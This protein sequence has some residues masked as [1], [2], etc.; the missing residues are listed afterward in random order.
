LAAVVGA[1]S[2][3]GSLLVA[4]VPVPKV[5]YR[6]VAA[7]RSHRPNVAAPLAQRWAHGVQLGA[8]NALTDLGEQVAAA[9][10]F[11]EDTPVTPEIRALL[12]GVDAGLR[13]GLGKAATLAAHG[14]LA[15]ADDIASV[16]AKALAAVKQTRA[17]IAWFAHTAI[18]AG[19]QAVAEET[20][21]QLCWV[22]ERDA[23]L[24]CLALSG[25]VVDP[26]EEFPASAT[27]GTHQMP[28]FPIHE[29]AP[30]LGPP[31]HPNCR[32]GLRLVRPDDRA[33]RDLPAALKR[34]AERSVAR[35][36]SNHASNRERLTAAD[37][38]LKRTTSRLPKTVR[39]RAK[40]DMARGQFS[41]RHNRNLPVL[42]P[43]Q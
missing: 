2:I 12:R 17:Q 3:A 40:K 24:V 20:G 32:C 33:S 42:P 41:G 19:T 10:G 26:G 36:F 8:G 37:R 31:R 23:C 15:T 25:E 38:L 5:R 11:A 1:A 4:G 14:P 43:G 22:A 34:E 9:R 13:D 16:Q 30:L 35:G 7:L 28:L 39:E 6:L 27:F 18:S 29:P 21:A